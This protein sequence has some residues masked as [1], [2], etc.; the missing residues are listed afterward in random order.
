LGALR[1]FFD[2]FS[3]RIPEKSSDLQHI[4]YYSIKSTQRYKNHPFPAIFSVK[5]VNSSEERIDISFKGYISSESFFKP[6]VYR[7]KA[8]ESDAVLEILC[9]NYQIILMEYLDS[10]LFDCV[11][12]FLLDKDD[13]KIN[14]ERLLESIKG[15][16]ESWK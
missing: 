12:N 13:P 14:R 1:F 16:L 11:F 10:S 9:D 15:S 4:K 6:V 7:V 5:K 3:A 8:Q 2:K